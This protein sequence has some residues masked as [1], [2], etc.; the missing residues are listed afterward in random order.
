ME[1][2]RTPAGE[3]REPPV[4]GPGR[5]PSGE[6]TFLTGELQLRRGGVGKRFQVDWV[7]NPA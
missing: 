5:W 6:K 4:A 7:R 2:G 1:I 3:L